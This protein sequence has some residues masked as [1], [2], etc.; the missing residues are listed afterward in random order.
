MVVDGD[1]VL[2]RLALL[3]A[4][5]FEVA[6]EPAQ[7]STPA[8]L[9]L[10]L[11]PDARGR[12]LRLQVMFLP[13]LD[14]PAVIQLSVGLPYAFDPDEVGPLC[15]FLCRLNTVLP[16]GQFGLFEEEGLLYFR[17][18]LP[19]GPGQLDLDLVGWSMSTVEYLVGTLGPLVEQVAAGLDLEE[20][21]RLMGALVGSAPED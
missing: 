17:A 5:D 2:A 14:D 6:L 20:A 21:R 4:D 8:Q 1:A 10:E 16:I 3:L 7:G 13:D 9:A 18:N 15:R 11:E 19:F 12:V